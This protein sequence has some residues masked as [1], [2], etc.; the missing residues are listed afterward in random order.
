VSFV[1]F[2]WF[3][4]IILG[5]FTC[6]FPIVC[7]IPLVL[8]VQCS[9]FCSLGSVLLSWVVLYV[10]PPLPII[11]LYYMFNA[12]CFAFFVVLLSWVVSYVDSSSL[13]C[14][15]CSVFFVLFCLFSFIF[16]GSFVCRF[17]IVLLYSSCIV[18]SVSFVLLSCVV[19]YGDSPNV[20]LYSS[21]IVCSVSFVLFSLSYI[22]KLWITYCFVFACALSLVFTNSCVE[23][24][25]VFSVML[26]IC[27]LFF[28]FRF[29]LCGIIYVDSS[30]CFVV[31]VL[32]VGY[33]F[34][35]CL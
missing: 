29:C 12:L 2:S 20:L 26:Y 33:P 11:L 30:S 5:S 1:L 23:F 34:F 31:F 3:C 4:F 32:V 21:C 22:A 25:S 6:R 9:L 27:G 16:L 28:S 19:S 35:C 17:F 8:Y 24:F 10:N 14:I 13:C 15:V 7:Y 18:C